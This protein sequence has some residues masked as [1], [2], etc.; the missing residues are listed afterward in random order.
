M[1]LERNWRS[2]GVFT[3]ALVGCASHQVD[4]APSSIPETQTVEYVHALEFTD[5][6]LPRFVRP[7]D[8]KPRRSGAHYYQV[9]YE[10]SK[11]RAAFLVGVVGENKADWSRPFATIYRWTG[12]GFDVG[13]RFAENTMSHG[14]TSGERWREVGEIFLDG[15]VCSIVG[16]VGMAVSGVG[17]LVIGTV[18]SV[19]QI[20]QELQRSVDPTRE[21]LLMIMRLSYDTSGR[22]SGYTF[23][24]PEGRG[25][26]QLVTTRC[27]YDDGVT[28]PRHCVVESTPEQ[29]TRK[30]GYEL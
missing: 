8:S 27:I 23:E 28:R 5:D 30:T 6:G 18:A 26:Q 15:F 3:I 2:L 22:L 4:I 14:C 29:I 17:G 24:L 16:V 10:N 1:K 21:R 7:L 25:G 12:K 20:S 13:A 11:P 19:P 9:L